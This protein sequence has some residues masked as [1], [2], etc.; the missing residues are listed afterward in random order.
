MEQAGGGQRRGR[1]K[2]KRGGRKRG[3]RGERKMQE[4]IL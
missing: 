3:R 2:S 1:E 4:G